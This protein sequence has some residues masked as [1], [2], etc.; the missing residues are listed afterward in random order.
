M[1]GFIIGFTFCLLLVLVLG[2]AT[3]LMRQ[4]ELRNISATNGPGAGS[5]ASGYGPE[6]HP[7]Q[8]VEKQ[9][10]TDKRSEASANGSSTSTRSPREPDGYNQYWDADKAF[11]IDELFAVTSKY[12]IR[13]EYYTDRFDR[14]PFGQ[15]KTKF[16]EPVYIVRAMGRE[17]RENYLFIV[18]REF[19]DAAKNYQKFTKTE[20][21]NFEYF[22]SED[23]L[24]SEIFH[25]RFRAKM[26]D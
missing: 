8:F 12:T 25:R 18:T 3:F 7:R 4:P 17:T 6:A 22:L 16:F 13:R 2:G 5:A 1:K 14:T 20:M 10:L 19:Y 24:N 21:S 23:K 9:S 11:A 15:P 26:I